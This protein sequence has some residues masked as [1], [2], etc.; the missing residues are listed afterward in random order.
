MEV[1]LVK[2]LWRN[3]RVEEAQCEHEDDMKAHYLNYS[4]INYIPLLTLVCITIKNQKCNLRLLHRYIYDKQII[5]NIQALST[6]IVD[7]SV[8]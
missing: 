7:Y 2:I 1:V 8:M 4:F 3:H 6:D 5:V